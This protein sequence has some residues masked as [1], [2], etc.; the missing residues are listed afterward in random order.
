MMT[1][2]GENANFWSGRFEKPPHQLFQ[3]LN[4]SITFDW[5]LAPY[6][7]QG[8][9]AHARMLSDIGVLTTEEFGEIEMG[10]GQIMA[11]IAQGQFDF[12][13]AD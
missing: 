9:I 10:L 2:D 3:Q 13:L 4:A 1:E 5:R 6:D 8:S 7:I 12:Q 11:E